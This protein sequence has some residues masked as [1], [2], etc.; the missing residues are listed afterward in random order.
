[1]SIFYCEIKLIIDKPCLIEWCKN[2]GIRPDKNY[3]VE[4]YCKF[5]YAP[6]EA[7]T[8]SPEELEFCSGQLSCGKTVQNVPLEV[9]CLLIE[10][11]ENQK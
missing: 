3:A 7:S 6:Y 9:E 4:L 5:Y 10:K 1:M 11:L 2:E 8:G